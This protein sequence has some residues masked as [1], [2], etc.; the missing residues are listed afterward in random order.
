M[1]E[2][3]AYEMQFLG[4]ATNE[5]DIKLE[6]FQDE[7]YPEYEKVYNECFIEM[8][9]VLD[10]K[11]YNFY[12]SLEQLDNKKQNIYVLRNNNTIMGS[13]A[14]YG[15]EI[16]DLIVNKKYQNKGIGKQLLFWAIKYIRNINNDPIALNV[17]KWNDKALR[18]YLNNGFEIN[19]IKKIR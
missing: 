12:S 10:I 5:T 11:P 19:K 4:D 18:I 6:V 16:D 1:A 17:A 2:I 13:V 8:R 3:I 9:K 7:F 14:C 15:N